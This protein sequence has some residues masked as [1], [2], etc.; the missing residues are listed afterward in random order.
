LFHRVPYF[1]GAGPEGA[2]EHPADLMRQTMPL[3][4]NGV[5]GSTHLQ[6]RATSTAS[7]QLVMSSGGVILQGQAQKYQGPYSDFNS[8]DLTVTLPDN[9]GGAVRYDMV[10]VRVEDPDFEGSRDRMLD[11][12]IFVETITGV[13]S[14]AETLADAG[15]PGY[16]A[17]P[18]ARVKRSSSSNTFGNADITDIRQLAKPRTA[19]RQSSIQHDHTTVQSVVKADGIVAFPTGG[20]MNVTV[21]EWANLMDVAISLHGVRADGSDSVDHTIYGAFYIE[22]AGTNYASSIYNKDWSSRFIEFTGGTGAAFDCT[23]VQGQQVIVRSMGEV[24]SSNSGTTTSHALEA[25]DTS[26]IIQ[27]YFSETVQ[28]Y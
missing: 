11:D 21:P 12:I 1:I 15:K 27:V 4:G 5:E 9:N 19:F 18:I 3:A 22:I 2:P 6:P 16:T 25:V 17:T 8:G 10:V 24:R 28:P 23:S 26:T 14:T 20:E 13:S 7:N